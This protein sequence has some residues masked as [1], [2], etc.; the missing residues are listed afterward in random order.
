MKKKERLFYNIVEEGDRFKVTYSNGNFDF[1]NILEVD[2]Y[3]TLTVDF[4][5][6]EPR[7]MLYGVFT[8]WNDKGYLKLQS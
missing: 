1:L 5:D 7:K 3:N 4:G 6:G 2:K 8:N